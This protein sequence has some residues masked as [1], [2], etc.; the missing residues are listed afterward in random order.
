MKRPA[1]VIFK[2]LLWIQGIILSSLI[3]TIL[4]SIPL[5]LYFDRQ[6]RVG[7]DLIYGL[8]LVYVAGFLFI[9]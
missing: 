2:I 7:G 3:V 5:W 4:T 1:T 6:P 9:I 8:G